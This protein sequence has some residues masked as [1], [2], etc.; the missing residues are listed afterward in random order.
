MRRYSCDRPARRF[1]S[2]RYPSAAPPDAPGRAAR[3]S[4]R[5]GAARAAPRATRDLLK[6]ALDDAQPFV[7]RGRCRPLSLVSRSSSGWTA[8]S[9]PPAA[10]KPSARD[11]G[12]VADEVERVQ[13]RELLPNRRPASAGAGGGGRAQVAAR[14]A[15]RGA[16][17]RW[18]R[19]ESP[20]S[21]HP[22][23]TDQRQRAPK[24][25]HAPRWTT[26]CRPERASD[27]AR[28]RP[29]LPRKQELAGSIGVIGAA[30]QLHR[31]R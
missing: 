26:A 31:R 21:R 13:R 2:E 24:P 23:P 5:H 3:A 20:T 18:S 22:L 8:S 4:P 10:A 28:R 6:P 9:M 30:A 12:R 29:L 27:E 1:F 25:R 14:L 19:G 11:A 15:P 17:R 7:G 16:P